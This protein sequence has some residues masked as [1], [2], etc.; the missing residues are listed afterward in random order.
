MNERIIQKGWAVVCILLF[1][2]VAVA[3]SINADE[4]I[5]TYEIY[6]V[7][8]LKKVDSD[9]IKELPFDDIKTLDDDIKLPLLYTIVVFIGTHRLNRVVR[10]L[11]FAVEFDYPYDIE[12]VYPLLFGYALWLFGSIVYW[13]LFWQN[14]SD[15]FGLDWDLSIIYLGD[16]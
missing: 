6:N 8:K 11:N 3:P 2:G 14:I 9:G 10:I 13:E 7:E 15:A 12:I 16:R 4:R 5:V 1:I